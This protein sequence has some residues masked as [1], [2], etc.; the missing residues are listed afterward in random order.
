M[1]RKGFLALAVASIAMVGAYSFYAKRQAPVALSSAGLLLPELNVAE[2]SAIRIE[3]A[4]Q[5]LYLLR[6]EHGWV[7]PEKAHYP[8]APAPV[9]QL[10]RQLKEASKRE[11]RT[12][13]PQLHGR[14]GLALSGSAAE[15]GKRLSLEG[16]NV[17]LLLGN[18]AAQQGQL[19]RLLDDPQSWVVT[20]ELTAPTELQAWLDLRITDIDFAEIQSVSVTLSEGERLSVA[21]TPEQPNMQVLGLAPD[22]KLAYEAAANGMANV[23]LNW[24]FQDVVPIAAIE[25]EAPVLTLALTTF[26]GGA[27]EAQVHQ[28]GEQF[29]LVVTAVSELAKDKVAASEGWAFLIESRHY[30]ALAHNLKAVLKP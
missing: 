28:K 11:A 20:P 2:V 27:F 18:Q 29:W 23:F 17:E 24:Q 26:A 16:A 8:A 19:M 22:S 4:E 9:A 3:H 13:N 25:L 5:R 30:Q 6:T 15:Q 12:A 14:L 7:L 1:G 10:L 21:R